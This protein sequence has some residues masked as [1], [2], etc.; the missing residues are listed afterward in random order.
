MTTNEYLDC[1]LEVKRETQEP[2]AI[3]E[4]AAYEAAQ[5]VSGS[6]VYPLYGMLWQYDLDMEVITEHLE[7]LYDSGNHFGL[8]YFIFILSDAVNYVLLRTFS[9][10]SATDVIVPILS[11]AI[12]EDWLEYDATSGVDVIEED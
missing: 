1:L 4:A 7:A 2:K 11:A 10:M 3:D 9:E 8:V 5:L 12:I 6:F